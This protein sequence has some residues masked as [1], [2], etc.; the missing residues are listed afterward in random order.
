MLGKF[1]S[2]YSVKAELPHSVLDL[3]MAEQ[4]LGSL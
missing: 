1:K 2:I 4:D 3:G